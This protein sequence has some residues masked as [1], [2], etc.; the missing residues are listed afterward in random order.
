MSA[1][2]DT[3]HYRARVVRTAEIA[4]RMVRVTVGEITPEPGHPPLGDVGPADSFFGLWVPVPDAEPASLPAERTDLVLPGKAGPAK[5]RRRL[6]KDIGV[7]IEGRRVGVRAVG[8][9]TD[10]CRRM[11]R[12]DR[13]RH[14]IDHPE[15]RLGCDVHD[16]TIRPPGKE[17]V[18]GSVRRSALKDGSAPFALTVSQPIRR[19]H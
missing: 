15:K 7:K 4:A 17:S 1:R 10:Q 16:D 9:T 5:R 19:T 14:L 8:V 12:R 2:V 13:L 3:P 11:V 6:D 18:L